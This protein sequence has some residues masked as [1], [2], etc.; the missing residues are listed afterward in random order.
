MQFTVRRAEIADV[1]AL[2]ALRLEALSTD[3]DAF[4]STYEREVRTTDEEWQRWLAP[5]V[6]FLF[7]SD[8]QSAGIVAG[9]RDRE[10]QSVA[11]LMAMWVRAPFRGTGAAGA[12]VSAVLAWA[13]DGDA[14]EL[15]LKVVD[16]NERAR[17]SYERAGF[18]LTGCRNER[19]RDGA[20]E[21]EMVCAV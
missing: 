21:L 3:P 17:R 2:R 19:E 12:L 13:A 6:T 8:G 5:G 9:V 15:R 4:G 7:E 14:K 16:S 11:W 18:R 20:I 10:D 1:P